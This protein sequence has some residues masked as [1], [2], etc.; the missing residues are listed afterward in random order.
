MHPGL[1]HGPGDD[2]VIP[3]DV[4]TFARIEGLVGEEHA[5]LTIPAPER[6]R[7]QHERLHHISSELD[8]IFEHLRER[9]ERIARHRPA[10][11]TSS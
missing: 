2:G 5:L 11:D 9:G 3:R 8:R 10:H 6:T 7:E 1:Q 4:A